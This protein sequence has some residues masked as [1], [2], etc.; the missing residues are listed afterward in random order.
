MSD[1]HAKI[2]NIQVSD[3]MVR[4]IAGQNLI[5]HYKLGHRDARHAAA[6]L[7]TSDPICRAAPVMLAALKAALPIVDLFNDPESKAVVSIIHA[8]IL[9]A[10]GGD[11]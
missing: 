3:E 6:S 7:A 8:A 1:L 2:M 4:A 5:A 10:E 9:K 11:A